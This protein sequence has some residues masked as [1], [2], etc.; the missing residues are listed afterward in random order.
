MRSLIDFEKALADEELILILRLDEVRDH[1]RWTREAIEFMHRHNIPF[2][3]SGNE[4][5]R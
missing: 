5:E 1:L 2:S 3:Q 4:N